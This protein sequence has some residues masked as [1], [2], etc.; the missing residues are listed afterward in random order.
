MKHIDYSDLFASIEA[1]PGE[2]LLVTG[3]QA[4]GN[5]MFRK[6]HAVQLA[7]KRRGV[8]VYTSIRTGQLYVCSIVPTVPAEA[9]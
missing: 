9:K 1:Q 8:R 3:D 6:A 7:A 5:D 2:W 4:A